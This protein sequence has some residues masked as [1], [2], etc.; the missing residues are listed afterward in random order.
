MQNQIPTSFNFHSLFLQPLFIQIFLMHQY[1]LALYQMYLYQ[2]RCAPNTSKE[3]KLLHRIDCTLNLL[4]F[5]IVSYQPNPLAASVEVKHKKKMEK[6][7]IRAHREKYLSLVDPEAGEPSLLS[8]Q[9][10]FILTVLLRVL[11]TIPSG[12]PTNLF[13]DETYKDEVSWP[14]PFTLHTSN[15]PVYLHAA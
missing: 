15:L 11:E 4:L 3:N 10:V 9:R 5:L 6:Q 7:N 14:S 8:A 1:H 13:F 12:P 2:P